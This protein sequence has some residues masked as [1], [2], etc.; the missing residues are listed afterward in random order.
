MAERHAQPGIPSGPHPYVC[1]RC[2]RRCGVVNLDTGV[3]EC[4]VC[5][6]LWRGPHL[7]LYR[8][9]GETGVEEFVASISREIGHAED[10]AR[11]ERLT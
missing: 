3:S 2:G 11:P 9:G 10:D 6:A 1:P 4:V 8:P 7:H 5:G